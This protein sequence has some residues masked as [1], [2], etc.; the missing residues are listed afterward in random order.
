MRP[1]DIGIRRGS[2]AIVTVDMPDDADYTEV[3]S[4]RIRM[5]IQQGNGHTLTKENAD[6]NIRDGYFFAYLTASET[7][8]FDADPGAPPVKAIVK[9]ATTG[10]LEI[11]QTSM[12]EIEVLDTLDEETI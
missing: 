3:V 9:W 11:M 2:T 12:K 1:A 5:T 4:T 6:V 10:D 7:L 8:G